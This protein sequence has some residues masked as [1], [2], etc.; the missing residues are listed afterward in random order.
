M[1]VQFGWPEVNGFPLIS[2]D[3]REI[4]KFLHAGDRQATTRTAADR[5]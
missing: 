4:L 2:L 3:F 5:S 1:A